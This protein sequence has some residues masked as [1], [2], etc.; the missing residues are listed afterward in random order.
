MGLQIEKFFDEN[1]MSVHLREGVKAMAKK[2]KPGDWTFDAVSEKALA[3]ETIEK[4]AEEILEAAQSRTDS[5]IDI[6]RPGSTIAQIGR[7]RIVILRPPLSDGWEIT[8]VRPVKTLKLSDYELSEKLKKRISEQA[9]GILIAGAPGMGKSTFSQALAT[10]FVEQ[11]KIVKTVEAPRDLVVPDTVTQLALSRGT[12]EEVHDILLLSRPDY[13]LFDEMRNPK[14]FELFADLRL[15]GVG[16]VGVVHGTCPMDAIQRFIG[17]LDLGVIPHVIDTV[18]F[19]KNGAISQVLAIKME[20][21]VPSGMTEADLARPVVV[22]SDFETNK[23]V[24]EIY[25]YGEETVVVPVA[26]QKATGAKRLAAEQIKRVFQKYVNHVDV[27]VVSD[28]KAIVS[29]PEKQ[30]P[31]IIGAG[32]KN[33][34][35]LEEELGI[36]LEVREHTRKEVTTAG[37]SIPYQMTT[38]GKTLIFSVPVSYVGKDITLYISDE[39]AGTFNVDRHGNVYIKKTSGIGKAILDAHH[40]GA[41]VRFIA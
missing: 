28:N 40:G 24:A 16:M 36:S 12:P 25:S 14:D 21:K 26:E 27:D 22:I 31:A 10:N 9:E 7:Y 20:V 6:D 38:K 29:I 30:I 11:G 13:S 19:I 5:F 1:T 39:Q 2:G 15:A 34:Q 4:M 35:R 3:A 23:A 33:I 8:A 32:G 17:K 37:T 18:V 41:K